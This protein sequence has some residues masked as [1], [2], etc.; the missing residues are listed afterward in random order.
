M[1]RSSTLERRGTLALIA[2]LALAGS[3]TGSRAATDPWSGTWVLDRGCSTLTGQSI[4]IERVRTGYHFDFG[5][6]RF[7]IGDDGRF[8]PTVPGRSTS[9]RPVGP[10]TWLRI[11]RANGR[12]FER[13]IL[14][15]TPD[16]R[17]LV[18]DSDTVDPEGGVHRSQDVENRVGTGQGLAG[19]WRSRTAGINVP[20]RIVLKVLDGGRIR[21]G[22]P[23]D[24]NYFIVTPDGPAAV[25]QG[26]RATSDARLTLR[27]V[28]ARE[29]RWTVTLAGRPFQDGIDTLSEA[30]DLIETSWMDKLPGEKQRAVY[31]RQ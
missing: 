1:S 31:R 9:I 27:R 12:D 8:Y 29:L 6:V 22:A 5:A 19:T 17:S 15:V 3:A 14:R 26:P 16:Q 24:R 13:S 23:E 28:S 21:I 18:I 20:A 4:E 25:N 7:D 2:F 10:S 11:H 30:G